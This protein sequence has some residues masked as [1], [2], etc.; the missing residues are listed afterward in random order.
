MNRQL[1][2]LTEQKYWLLLLYDGMIFII[3]NEDDIVIGEFS[4]TSGLGSHV[5]LA[6]ISILHLMRD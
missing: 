5:R 2:L 6:C 1:L 4:T 3:F